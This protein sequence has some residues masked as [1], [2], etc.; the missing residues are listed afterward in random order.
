MDY[1]IIFHK[2]KTATFHEILYTFMTISLRNIGR[3]V[4]ETTIIMYLKSCISSFSKSLNI[5][6]V[7]YHVAL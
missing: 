7:L 6:N 4:S 2:I 3:L 1:S 5:N